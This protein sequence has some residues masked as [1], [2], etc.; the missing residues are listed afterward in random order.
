MNILAEKIELAK[1]ILSTDDTGIIKKV[2]ALFKDKGANQ[3]DDLPPAV[4]QS[5]NESIEQANKGEFVAFDRVKEEVH[6]LLK[7]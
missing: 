7:K 3:W 5:I 6:A 4:K 2:K 1:L